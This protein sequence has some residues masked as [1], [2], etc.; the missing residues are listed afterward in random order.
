MKN[1]IKIS[2]IIPVYN[3]EQYLK[4]CLNS[5]IF[6][7]MKEIEIICVNDGSTDK[8][9]NILKDYAKKDK[10]IIVINQKNS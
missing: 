9:L 7:S 2:I 6:Q 4:Q 10:R 8:S 3:R 1:S 5:I